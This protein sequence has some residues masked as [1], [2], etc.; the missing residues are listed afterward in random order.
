MK[1]RV[2]QILSEELWEAEI[3]IR[4]REGLDPDSARSATINRWMRNG[5]LQPFQAYIDKALCTNGAM[6][7]LDRTILDCLAECITLGLL[8]AKPGRK[9][10]SPAKFAWDYTAKLLYDRLRADDVSHKK[11]VEEVAHRLQRPKSIGS[12]RK[13]VA[14]VRKRNAVTVTRVR[15]P[16]EK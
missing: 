11:A 7:A 5:N 12:V 15:K 8:V 6:I 4:I 13:A 2:D 16:S 14:N 10:R 9:R 3:K 1:H